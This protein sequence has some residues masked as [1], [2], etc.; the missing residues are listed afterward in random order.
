MKRKIHNERQRTRRPF[1]DST[2]TDSRCPVSE[3]GSQGLSF[4]ATGAFVLVS[5]LLLLLGACGAGQRGDWSFG[6]RMSFTA[7]YFGQGPTRSLVPPG[8][9]KYPASVPATPLIGRVGERGAEIRFH[10]P[11]PEEIDGVLAYRL[12]GIVHQLLRKEVGIERPAL[13]VLLFPVSSAGAVQVKVPLPSSPGLA[14]GIPTMDGTL[15]PVHANVLV[16]LLAHEATEAF[17]VYPSVGGGACLYRDRQNR[18]VGEGMAN[19]LASLAIDATACEGLRIAP[20][21]FPKVVLDDSRRGRGSIRLEGWLPGHTSEGR[22]AAAEY[23]CHRWYQAACERGHE[24]PIAE[25]AAWLR[26]IPAGP[27]HRQALA[28]LEETSGIDVGRQA[29]GVSI[30]EVLRYH[31]KVWAAR[32]WDVPPEAAPFR[33]EGHSP[34]SALMNLR[35]GL[36]LGARMPMLPL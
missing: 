7:R 29:Q 23:L 17:M 24:H 4:L 18:W 6:P 15:D 36:L 12:A 8:P 13:Y 16:Y 2:V 1:P 10:E 32:A 22:Y 35:S 26:T 9:V 11:S 21:G 27:R 14:A 31:T 20:R 3:D 25:F 28:W 5:F 30:D 34:S 33:E 19:L